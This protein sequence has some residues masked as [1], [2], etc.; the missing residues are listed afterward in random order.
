M[1]LSKYSSI[2][3]INEKYSLLI[4]S[5]HN[6]F[7]IIQNNLLNYIISEKDI[8]LEIN[9][10]LENRGHSISKDVIKNK[11]NNLK[12]KIYI[13]GLCPTYSCN[14]NCPYCYQG[15]LKTEN[16]ANNF[17]DFDLNKLFNYINELIESLHKEGI[18]KIY[19]ELFGGEPLQK[20]NKHF[21]TE[22]AKY[23]KSNKI[24]LIITTNG[25]N[26]IDFLDILCIYKESIS[27]VSTTLDDVGEKQDKMRVP[28]V[29]IKE[30]EG[31]KRIVKGINSCLTLG[32]PVKVETNISKYNCDNI[33][34][35]YDFC[36]D[37]SWTDN[38]LFSYGIGRVD[39]RFFESTDRGI[40]DEVDA[41]AYI[42][43]KFGKILS[44]N[45]FTEKRFTIGFLKTTYQLASQFNL[46]FNQNEYGRDHGHYCWSTSD[47]IKG[48]YIDPLFDAYRCTYTVGNKK[49]KS[50]NLFDKSIENKLWNSPVS[51]DKHI[52]QDCSILGYCS[53]GCRISELFDFEKSCSYEKKVFDKFFNVFT[54]QI[55]N[56]CMSMIQKDPNCLLIPLN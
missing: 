25:Y 35:V 37:Q 17:V 21:I 30:G 54:K 51:N 1:T 47:I 18:K 40:L 31:F 13:L 22:I 11:S 12:E 6:S 50:H 41:L 14:Y 23:C 46:D 27:K 10:F 20:R 32:I 29:H 55:K 48:Y 3:K 33:N 34:T 9:H 16:S 43:E 38:P 52:C 7:D 5:I 15:Y 24:G 19:I 26:I 56:H 8:D 53:G 44:N 36:D 4:N 28:P 45:I 49:L 42:S 39:N 2:K